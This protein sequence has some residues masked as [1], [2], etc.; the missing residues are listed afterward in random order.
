MIE[1]AK[2]ENP[3]D[4]IDVWLVKK[5]KLMFMLIKISTK[6]LKRPKRLLKVTMNYAGPIEAP[7]TKNQKIGKLKVVYDQ[8]LLGEYDLLA[9]KDIRKVNIFSRLLK[10]INYLIWGDV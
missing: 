5:M 10:S 9:S 7:I 3:I 1:I 8:N 2:S 4:K 6:Q